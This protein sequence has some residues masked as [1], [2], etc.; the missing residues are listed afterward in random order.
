MAVTFRKFNQ[1]AAAQTASVVAARED[2]L[3]PVISDTTLK[4]DAD[5]FAKILAKAESHY[6]KVNDNARPKRQVIQL[7]VRDMNKLEKEVA[8]RIDS[9]YYR[10]AALRQLLVLK[11]LGSVTYKQNVVENLL[12]SGRIHVSSKGH[13]TAGQK[14]K[15]KE[16]DGASK[17]AKPSAEETKAQALV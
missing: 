14:R 6:Q 7:F 13:S 11:G 10:T 17:K 9:A 15:S 3:N 5:T 12:E 16:S 1:A 4:K 2:I 8:N